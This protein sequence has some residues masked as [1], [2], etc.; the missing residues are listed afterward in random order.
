MRVPNHLG[1]LKQD[2]TS[3]IDVDSAM[4]E[5]AKLHRMLWLRVGENYRDMVD[6]I[7]PYDDSGLASF[8]ALHHIR[9]TRKTKDALRI[10]RCVVIAAVFKN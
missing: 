4:Q 5:E 10:A 7:R 9:A 1:L 2:K 6:T 3:I 8:I